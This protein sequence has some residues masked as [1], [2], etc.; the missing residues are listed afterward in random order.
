MVLVSA[1]FFVIYPT[2]ALKGVVLAQNRCFSLSHKRINK[3]PTKIH[4]MNRNRPFFG[5]LIDIERH[6]LTLLAERTRTGLI[7]QE[8]VF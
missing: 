5:N 8:S 4:V 6:E 1:Q 7:Y 2:Q 3:Y